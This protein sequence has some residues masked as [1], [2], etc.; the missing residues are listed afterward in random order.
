MP[1][2]QQETSSSTSAQTETQQAEP[3]GDGNYRVQQGDCMQSIAARRG[4]LWETLWNL[5]ENKQLKET[6][7]DPNCLLPGDRV[8]IPEP[9][10]HQESGAT[11]QKHRFRRKGLPAMLRLQFENE[12]E[13]LAGQPFTFTTDLT[14][15]YEG[16]TDGDG[17]AEIPIPTGAHHGTI[18]IGEGEDQKVYEVDLGQLDPHD[19]ISGVQARLNNLGYGAGEVDGRLNARTER[20]L[21]Q[22]QRQQKLEITGRIDVKTCD[23][24]RELNG[25]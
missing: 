24:L 4:F 1:D 18:R 17:V 15:P 6:R 11:E 14:E 7:K 8:H 20:A 22:F 5:P 3:V 21:R 13:A 23:K 9:R 25:S 10:P 2:E 16:T 12:G 19:S